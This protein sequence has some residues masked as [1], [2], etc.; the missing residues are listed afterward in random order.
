MMNDWQQL[1]L[2]LNLDIIEEKPTI[3]RTQNG[4]TL[5]IRF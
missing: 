4:S 2:D 3:E 5:Y 1:T